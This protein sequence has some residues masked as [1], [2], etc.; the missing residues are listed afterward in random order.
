[1][2]TW[3]WCLTAIPQPFHDDDR[4]TFAGFAKTIHLMLMVTYRLPRSE[5]IDSAY[6]SYSSHTV[7][8]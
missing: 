6:A 8:M 1:M 5:D 7:L 3:R 2:M 4:F